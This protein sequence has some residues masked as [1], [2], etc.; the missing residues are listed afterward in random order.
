M[1]IG[2]SPKISG[3]DA[4][5]TLT[6][7]AG[8]TWSVGSPTSMDN[9]YVAHLNAGNWDLVYGSTIP[10]NTGNGLTPVTSKVLTSFSPFTF[11]FSPSTTLPV[12]L[13]NFKA[14][15]VHTAVELLWI[16]A[17]ESSLSR[18]DLER[19]SDG[20]NFYKI[21]SVAA[22]NTSLIKSY[23]WLDN[24]PIQG[25]NF[26]KLKMINLDGVFTFSYIVEI[27]MNAKEGITVYP[28]PVTGHVIMLKMYGQ[29]KG[30]YGINL[31][32]INGETVMNSTIIHDGNDA[33]LTLN[34]NRN[35][36]SGCYYLKI[37][38]PENSTTF[39]LLIN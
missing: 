35:L 30:L 18:Y 8:N 6:Y 23:N 10:G 15:R 25:L 27:N 20:S 16:S 19:S 3:P 21:G 5:V 32:N 31:F 11:G 34:L 28:N 37:I 36:A 13:I 29:P 26:Y 24:S 39:K 17:N 33:V 12:T 9:I 4:T 22:T 38:G 2:I 1:N 14:N 7:T